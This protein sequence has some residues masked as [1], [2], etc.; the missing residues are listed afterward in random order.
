MWDP[1]SSYADATFTNVLH[2]R[3][4]HFRVEIACSKEIV[5]YFHL[6]IQYFSKNIQMI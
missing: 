2:S 5:T 6:R 3:F 4:R 1:L